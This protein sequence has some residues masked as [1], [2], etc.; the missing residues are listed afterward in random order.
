MVKEVVSLPSTMP[1]VYITNDLYLILMGL[2]N[3]FRCPFPLEL[4]LGCVIQHFIKAGLVVHAL[5]CA[6]MLPWELDRDRYLKVRVHAPCMLPVHACMS[7][8]W[9]YCNLADP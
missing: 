1:V 4:D 2:C 7:H 9:G 3:C 5:S 8:V 6:S